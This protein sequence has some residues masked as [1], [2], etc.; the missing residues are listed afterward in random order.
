MPAFICV[1]CGIQYPDALTPPEACRICEDAR[2]YIGLDGQ[3]WTTLDALRLGHR[4]RFVQEETGL[5]SFSTEPKFG[6]GQRAFVV[7]AAGGSVLWDCVSLLDDQATE[8]IAD[9][10]SLLAIAISHPHYY[11]T[12]VEWSRTFGGVPIFLHLAD[13]QWVTRPDS[14]V[15]FWDGETQEIAPG[16]TLIRCGGH[17]EGGSVLHWASG[18]GGRGA[19]L[20]GDILQVAPDRRWVSFMYSYPNFIPLNASTVRRI[21]AAVE[22]FSFETIYG[23][24]PGMTVREDGKGAVARSVARYIRA[25]QD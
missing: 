12:C 11:A 8:A 17:F 24:F 25:I 9:A 1:T 7:P 5:S 19:L 22:P 21:V 13:R 10:G 4:S 15:R 20:S 2:Q 16:L 3:R 18:C 6:I 14:A 23:A